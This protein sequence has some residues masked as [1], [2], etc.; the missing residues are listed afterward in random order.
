MAPSFHSKTLKRKASNDLE[1]PRLKN[2]VQLPLDTPS[3]IL[4]DKSDIEQ[5]VANYLERNTP[6]E[7]EN[8]EHKAHQDE[9]QQLLRV[10]SSS[11]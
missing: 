6:R 11:G 5:R 10:S 4:A 8:G 1:N 2:S 7:G 9:S 3:N